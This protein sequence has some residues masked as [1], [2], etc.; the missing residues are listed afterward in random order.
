[1]N[2]AT[3][4]MCTHAH[5]RV[6]SLYKRVRGDSGFTDSVLYDDTGCYY[7]RRRRF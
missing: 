4:I 2:V 7:F 6:I 5:A 1:M 3:G